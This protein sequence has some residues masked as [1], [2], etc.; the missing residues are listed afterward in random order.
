MDD[1]SPYRMEVKVRNN[2]IISRVLKAGYK[3]IADFC[4]KVGIC[5]GSIS[6]IVAFSILPIKEDG[7]WRECV[8]DMSSALKCEPEDLFTERQRTL[9]A[10]RRSAIM[11]LAEEQFVAISHNIEGSLEA[12]NIVSKL[13]P[14]LTPRELDVI[15]ARYMDGACKSEVAEDYDRSVTRITHIENKALRKMKRESGRLQKKQAMLDTL[16]AFKRH[17]Q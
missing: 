9:I 11:G 7:E 14:V 4:N 12:K 1:V 3:S 13:L 2:L 5:Q 15:Q 16:R 10:K 6:A 8:W 17:E